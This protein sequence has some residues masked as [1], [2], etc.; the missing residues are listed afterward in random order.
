MEK[1]MNNEMETLGRFEGI[2]RDIYVGI[3]FRVPL[4]FG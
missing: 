1:N 2:Y 4:G 3:V